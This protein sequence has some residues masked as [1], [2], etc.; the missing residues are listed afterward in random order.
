MTKSD[1]SGG[2][3]NSNNHRRRNKDESTNT[4]DVIQMNKGNT[5]PKSKPF[6]LLSSSEI[7]DRLRLYSNTYPDLVTLKRAQDDFK[8]VPQA[9]GGDDDCPF[10]EN[11]KGCPNDYLVIEDK[12]MHRINY[13]SW[14]T[15][16]EIF[17]S[18]SVHGNER[19][20]PTAV[21]ETV[22]LLLESAACEAMGPSLPVN[23]TLY[24]LSSSMMER[25]KDTPPGF[26]TRQAE[27]CR[28]KLRNKWGVDDDERRWM[29]RLVSTRR[30]VVLPVANGT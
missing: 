30:I 2:N 27:K 23:D 6:H 11:I 12:T 15:L 24:W 17:L 19:V 4:L 21:V 7:H 14:S 1:N 29:A 26:H 9:A 20:G 5:H 28:T 18:G 22:G 16:P 3:S 25:N 13:E 8:Y 10:E